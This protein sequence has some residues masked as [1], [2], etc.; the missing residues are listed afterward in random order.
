MLDRIGD[1]VTNIRYENTNFKEEVQ[2]QNRMLDE[3]NEDMER[4]LENMVKLDTKL[5][6]MLTKA[7]TCRLWLCV[8]IELALMVLIFMFLS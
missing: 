1:V 2:L 3:V 6:T 8:I 7:S 4:N 5:K